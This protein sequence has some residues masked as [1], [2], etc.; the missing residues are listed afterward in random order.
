MA[1]NPQIKLI[2]ENAKWIKEQQDNTSYPLN[3][4]AYKERLKQDEEFA[5]KFKAISEYETTF[6]FNSLPY[7]LEFMAKDS[8]LKEK[9]EQWHKDLAKDI[10]IEEAL[11][12]LE[13]LQLSNIKRGKIAGIK[14]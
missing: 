4:N 10:Y 11:N 9:R 1:V 5:R 7:E 6:T 8:I 2:E 3:Y 14:G 12:V 13:D